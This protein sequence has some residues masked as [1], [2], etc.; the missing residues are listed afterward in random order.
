M[1]ISLTDNYGFSPNNCS[2]EQMSGSSQGHCYKL[3]HPLQ[4]TPPKHTHKRFTRTH[5]LHHLHCR[6]TVSQPPPPSSSILR[7]TFPQEPPLLPPPTTQQSAERARE[8]CNPWWHTKHQISHRALTS[9]Q[10]VLASCCQ[11][12][13]KKL[14]VLRTP[15]SHT[16]SGLTN[17]YHNGGFDFIPDETQTSNGVC[18]AAATY[19][20][21]TLGAM[22]R[23]NN[24]EAWNKHHRVLTPPP[25][26]HVEPSDTFTSALTCQSE[27]GEGD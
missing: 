26:P 15:D 2:Q 27:V 4:H 6:L 5:S 20:R 21:Q 24:G 11:E 19:W 13:K 3:K 9:S 14:V 18:G 8:S 25:I 10:Q 7:V 22:G 17:W 16:L 23:C 12:Q 1:N